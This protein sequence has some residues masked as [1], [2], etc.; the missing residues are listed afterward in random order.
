[1][2]MNMNSGYSG[3]SMSVRAAEA[4]AGGEMPKSKWTKKAIIQA[5]SSYCEE[6]DRAYDPQIEKL[7]KDELFE[8]FIEYTSWHHTSKY[9]NATDFYGINEEAVCEA[10]PRLPEEV[11]RQREAERA[12][13]RAAE[14]AAWEAEHA[15]EIELWRREREYRAEHGFGP[16]TVAAYLLAH[17]ENCCVRLSKKGNEVIEILRDKDIWNAGVYHARHKE[18]Q[19]LYHFNA[20]KEKQ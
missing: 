4:Y 7:K 20:A 3:W 16:N 15:E 18:T 9:C 14:K 2:G 12:A 13:R 1:M 6:T 11:C 10:F 17:P 19:T 8:R 5:V